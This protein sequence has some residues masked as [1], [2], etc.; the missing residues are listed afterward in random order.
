MWDNSVVKTDMH[1]RK[2]ARR[3][4]HLAPFQWP[5]GVSGNPKGRP[6]GKTLKEFAREYLQSLP[7][8]KKLEYLASLPLDITWRMAEGNPTEDK[9]V[10]ITV[11]KPILG[12]ATQSPEAPNL[13][14]VKTLGAEMMLEESKTNTEANRG[15]SYNVDCEKS[16]HENVEPTLPPLGQNGVVEVD[17]A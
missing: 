10:S 13:P 15:T 3:T 17:G 14:V 1:E 6:K 5:K 11:P 7:D 8:D 12:A 4:D 16:G 9:N 2:H